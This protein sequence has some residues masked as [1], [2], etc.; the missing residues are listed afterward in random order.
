M[1][2]NDSIKKLVLASLFA[3]FT[4]VATLIHIHVPGMQTGYVNLGDC[5]V[6]VSAVLL[7]PVYGS[8]AGG[9]GSALTDFLH[10]YVIYVPATFIIK[11]LMGIAVCFIYKL[12]SKDKDKYNL[13]VFPL[14][15]GGVFAE[16][17][18][19]CGYFLYEG[20]FIV[21]F[22]GAALGIFGNCI[23]GVFGVICSILVLKVLKKTKITDMIE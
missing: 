23:Q 3:A 2:T 13:K 10:G 16:L 19:V 5:L 7:G 8:L 15:L 22:A 18:M 12:A 6:I 1:K 4:F 14:I 11:T 17:I 9:I 21:N 20:L